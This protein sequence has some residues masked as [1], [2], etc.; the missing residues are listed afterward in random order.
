MQLLHWA[1]VKPSGPDN[2]AAIRFPSPLRVKSI[3]IFPSNSKPFEKCPDVVA[4]TEPETFF[5]QLYLNAYC[6]PKENN[7]TWLPNALIPTVMTYTGGM[8]DFPLDIGSSYKTSLLILKGSFTSLSLAIYGGASSPSLDEPAAAYVP[9]P[10]PEI[11]PTPLSASLDP[12]ATPDPTRVARSLLSLI[13][14]APQIS[15]VVRLMFC[16]KAS[17][18]DWDDPE[19]PHLYA[20]L[21]SVT[22]PSKQD[23]SETRSETLVKDDD[24]D[25][26]AVALSDDELDLLAPEPP[27]PV[28]LLDVGL[29][30]RASTLTSRPI[31]DS[32]PHETINLFAERV[33]SAVDSVLHEPEYTSKVAELVALI[34]SHS[35]SQH[36]QM[37]RAL[38]NTLPLKAIYTLS[39]DAA[40][41]ETTLT[42]L[43]DAACNLD[44]ASALSTTDFVRTFRKIAGL[45]VLNEPPPP[46]VPVGDGVNTNAHST[47]RSTSPTSPISPVSAISTSVTVQSLPA[48]EAPYVPPIDIPPTYS[49]VQIKLA[50]RLL[51]ILHT[52]NI[53]TDA[54]TN[55]GG[56][57]EAAVRGIWTGLSDTE[58]R[59]G[60]WIDSMVWDPKDHP[61]PVVDG[62]DAMA[63][64]SIGSPFAGQGPAAKLR[65]NAVMPGVKAATWAKALQALNE[66]DVRGLSGQCAVLA[67]WHGNRETYDGGVDTSTTS[68][69]R[70]SANPDTL[71][72]SEFIAFVRAFLG[73]GCVLAVWAWADSVGDSACIER[74]LAVIR[75]WQGV[76]GF[77][78]ITN[79]LLLLRQLSLRLGWI[80]G[81][82]DPP[83][84]AGVLAEKILTSLVEDPKSLIQHN[85]LSKTVLDLQLAGVTDWRD[86]E[87]E[88]YEDPYTTGVPKEILSDIPVHLLLAMR[89]LSL[90]AKDGLSG[91]LEELKWFSFE[92]RDLE[93]QRGGDAGGQNA[94]V[95]VIESNERRTLS[96]R[97]L[98]I[99]RLSLGIVLK[100]VGRMGIEPK[101]SN[102]RDT[103]API[104]RLHRGKPS[105]QEEYDVLEDIWVE[106]AHCLVAQLVDLVEAA[107]DDLAEY[108]KLMP[109]SPP[110][111]PPAPVEQS[112]SPS[113]IPTQV[114]E[115]LFLTAHDAMRLVHHLIS[116]PANDTP[117]PPLTTRS[118]RSLIAACADCFVSGDIADTVFGTS[119]VFGS[120]SGHPSVNAPGLLGSSG[121][122]SSGPGI[123]AAATSVRH[124]A[125]AI[126][127][128]LA[129]KD[130]RTS[131]GKS[132]SE[133]ALRTLLQLGVQ[134]A[135]G[136]R[137]REP[138][139]SLLQVFL[140]VDDFI[141][142]AK[143][144]L[145]GASP[146]GL[147]ADTPEGAAHSD[148]LDASM[149]HWVT[150]IFPSVLPDLQAFFRVLDLETRLHFIRRLIALD[151]GTIGI[152]EWLLFEELSAGLRSLRTV[153]TD[154]DPIT[155]EGIEK[156]K[157]AL[158]N[159]YHAHQVLYFAIE[160]F[161][162]PS[163][164]SSTIAWLLPGTDVS[165][166]FDQF[167]REIMRGNFASPLLA[168]VERFIK[169]HPSVN[170]S[171]HAL[172]IPLHLRTIQDS[173]SLT[174]DCQ[175][176]LDRLTSTP[177]PD[178]DT[179][180]LACEIGRTLD[181][182]ATPEATLEKLQLDTAESVLSVIQWLTEQ[183]NPK[184]L[185]LTGIKDV[186]FNRLCDRVYQM[187][188]LSRADILEGIRYSI[189]LDETLPEGSY[190]RLRLPESLSLSPQ[191]I[192]D[193]LH[194]QTEEQPVGSSTPKRRTPDVLMPVI[195]PPSAL[196]RSPQA[197]GLTKTYLNNDFRQ[198]RSVP[199]AR[200]NTSRLPS[201]HVDV[202]IMNAVV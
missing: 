113:V 129:A 19:F 161:T 31:A 139:A 77:R 105:I 92:R 100:E 27:E 81:D 71:D 59:V 132:G 57:F 198:L 145:N 166:A 177:V 136:L 68:V 28:E 76:E 165:E 79:H 152:G 197:T 7:R 155:A 170:A 147:V 29:L 149:G 127:R 118:M 93:K 156:D 121:D 84:H 120:T 184:L 150:S 176:I 185:T 122:T 17:N 39:P 172:T 34:L 188:P 137:G 74:S 144:E 95:E 86:E 187:V 52:Q 12:S 135:R 58:A 20:D 6:D 124:S 110:S 192:Q 180:M 183:S 169:D 62:E 38:V 103:P 133:I 78:E 54:L 26:D 158:V 97:R 72:H 182:F 157:Y 36:P 173:G 14:N 21:N 83:R 117:F 104:D 10:L 16:L 30:E 64:D 5:V 125:C 80:I 33:A 3:R 128:R 178:A 99:L 9:R 69:A 50:H 63:T 123:A 53:F 47:S 196:L 70:N 159:M 88:E 15:L 119:A 44:I 195:S 66:E 85:G 199:S 91:A 179:E 167:L 101:R 131:S 55:T 41:T 186:R 22:M 61:T 153:R 94:V 107:A 24:E 60:A 43:I 32:T 11:S 175:P 146:N 111:Q 163:S 193:L 190:G 90:V 201:M 109:Y 18:E 65:E 35:A 1:I 40:M 160:L 114:V 106:D 108:F 164:A 126:I 162:H 73:I 89:K 45:S 143:V 116:P 56:A 112:L 168:K 46:S 75:V 8:Q 181:V 102:P 49:K 25:Q 51:S 67:D 87:E 48:P 142:R 141:P 140:L 171:L 202:G 189:I 134:F 2:L 151:R 42:R 191:N 154:G 37:A 194:S 98:R 82:N 4:E 174:F 200:Q 13:P 115:Q 138:T 96:L 148:T 130:V 23:T